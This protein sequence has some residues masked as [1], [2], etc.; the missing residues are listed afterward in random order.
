MEEDSSVT[1]LS[2]KRTQTRVVQMIYKY[3]NE[4]SVM[5]LHLGFAV[6][7]SSFEGS[8]Y[9]LLCYHVHKDKASK[10]YFEMTHNDRETLHKLMIL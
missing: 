4:K 6:E 2:T 7:H 9:H 1:H 5:M 10:I 3:L 8:I